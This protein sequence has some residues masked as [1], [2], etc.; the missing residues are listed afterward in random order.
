M[1]MQEALENLHLE[2]Y[3]AYMTPNKSQRYLALDVLRGLTVCFMIIVNSGGTGTEPFAPLQ[4]AAWHGFTPTDLVFPTFLFVVGNAMAFS[5]DKFSGLGNFRVTAKILKRTAIIFLLGY[6]L[7]WFPFFK[8]MPNGNWELSPISQTRI[9]GVLQ[10]IALCYGIA[11]LM[12]HFLPKK[13]VWL[14]SILFLGGYWLAMALGGDYSMTG[15]LGSILDELILGDQHLYHGEGVAF[16]P[17]G[18][19]S[20]FPSVVNVIIGYY[21]GKFIREKGN[22]YETVSK[23]MVAGAAFVAIAYFWNHLFPINKKLW[24]SPFVLYTCGL[25]MLILGALIQVIEIQ[26][27][28]KFTQF[29]E[30]FGKNPLFIYLLSEIIVILLWTINDR[31]GKPLYDSINLNFFQRIAPGPW[32]SLFFALSVMF[33][34]WLAGWWMDKRKIYIRV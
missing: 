1:K 4:H 5:M 6:L 10:R 21:A 17:E 9:L 11:A 23:L 24:T 13:I 3:I 27:R 19:L 22:T 7:Y 30:V 25:A 16:E 29:F 12:I 33:I 15:N 18:L 2:S 20:T 14:V 31:Q 8:V 26:G 28:K 32:G 34:C